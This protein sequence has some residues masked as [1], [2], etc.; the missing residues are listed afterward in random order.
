[1]STAGSA[2]SPRQRE[3]LEETQRVAI[4]TSRL[5]HRR[6]T[7]P[8]T[9]CPPWPS[10]QIRQMNSIACPRPGRNPVMNKMEMVSLAPTTR[11]LL[12]STGQLPGTLTM[13]HRH[14]DLRPR[15]K[16]RRK[17][18]KGSLSHHFRTT[19]FLQ[20]REKRQRRSLKR[21]SPHSGST[22]K[23]SLLLMKI[24]K[25]DRQH[26][27]NSPTVSLRLVCRPR[28]LARYVDDVMLGTPF[29]FLRPCQRVAHCRH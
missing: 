2:S 6:V 29:I 1:M 11:L 16:N 12:S 28:G 8:T 7:W 17:M 27:R 3:P 15:K 20:P 21:A 25:K 10:V 26:C 4:A 14:P 19:Q 13:Y 22:F 18:P 24:P 23:R 5:E 9:D